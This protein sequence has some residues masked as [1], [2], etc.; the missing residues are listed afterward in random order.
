MNNSHL[1]EASFD[2]E[3]VPGPV[4]YAALLPKGYEG[5]SEY[6]L[7]YFLHGGGGDRNFLTNLRPVVDR[8]WDEERLPELIAV[9]P[10]VR[11]RCFYMDFKDGSEKWEQFMIG[12]FLDHLRR[13][14]KI[15]KANKE[16]YL[17]GISMGGMGGL[18]LAFKHP[19]LFSGVA[20]LEPGIEPALAFSEIEFEDRW[21]RQQELFETAFG[22]PVDENYWKANNPANIA[23]DHA[24]AIR[25]SG[26]AI[27]LDCGDEDSFGLHRG[28][29][30]LHR[31]LWDNNIKH[32]YH[33]V[34]G[35]DHLGRTIGPRTSEGLEFLGR[36]IDP[37]DPD[38]IAEG[39]QKQLAQWKSAV[40][41]Q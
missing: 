23:I 32:E 31:I 26:L 7:L 5:E 3:I 27:Y 35:A 28:T 21:W 24:T 40:E 13:T 14:Y 15:K 2:C 18:R 39:L 11:E 22:K 16:V 6:P 34:R 8:L 1:I 9:T 12:P 38:P 33:S 20:A 37:P 30:F 10:S 36:V 25:D 4:E 19:E 41:K 29:E 17:F